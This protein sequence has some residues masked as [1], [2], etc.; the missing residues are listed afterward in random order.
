MDLSVGVLK[1]LGSETRLTII[2]NLKDRR[3][4]A[5][6]LATRLKMHVSTVK[7]HLDFMSRTGLVEQ[8][9]EGRKWKYYS[10]TSGCKKLLSPYPSEIKIL[11]PLAL[12]LF[13]VGFSPNQ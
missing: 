4:T 2:K 12:V 9:N 5:T 8:L 10:L 7:E 13:A 3:M 1:A 11:I 6:E